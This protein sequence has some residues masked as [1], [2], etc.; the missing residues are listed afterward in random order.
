MR[1]NK[2]L[3]I[4]SYAGSLTLAATQAGFDITASMEDSGYALGTQKLNFPNLTYVDRLPWP[5]LHNNALDSTICIAHPPCSAFASQGSNNTKTFAA[6]RRGVASDHFACTRRVI[7]YAAD[8]GAA[9]IIIESVV[10]AYLGA[11]SFYA[12]RAFESG[13]DVYHILQNAATFGVPQ[14]RPRYWVVMIKHGLLPDSTLILH[15]KPRFVT[16][17]EALGPG[18]E[19]PPHP[20]IAK[21]WVRQRQRLYDGGLSFMQV[22]NMLEECTGRLDRVLSERF[23]VD[24]DL[25]RE[26]FQITSFNSK[27]FNLLDPNGFAPTVVGAGDYLYLGHPITVPELNVLAGF[28]P[29]YKFD[30][31]MMQGWYLSKGVAPPVAGWLLG[32]VRFNLNREV[33]PLAVGT[34]GYILKSGET[35][36]LRLKKAEALD[37]AN[38]QELWPGKPPYVGSFGVKFSN[39]VVDKNSSNMIG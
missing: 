10:G 37:L 4:N 22:D 27:V 28:P 33:Q 18:I 12:T 36:D 19:G 39:K 8:H 29:D 35:A 23:E 30:K 32:E 17:G 2:I 7:D 34:R 11:R 24:P 38:Q 13:Y 20:G 14:W 9:A 26:Q 3:V 31:P 21:D 16:I 5:D 25:V 15:H 6:A 1:Y